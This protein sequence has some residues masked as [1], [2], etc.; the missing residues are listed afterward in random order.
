MKR[1][2]FRMTVTKLE[3]RRMGR[4]E[5]LLAC[6]QGIV[7]LSEREELLWERFRE[8]VAAAA[9]LLEVARQQPLVKGSTGQ[10]RAN[11]LFDAAARCD[12]VALDLWRE[13]AA[14]RLEAAR[15]LGAALAADDPLAA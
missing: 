12:R 8:N 10:Q 1:S 11:P 5:A 4:E 7:E 6:V 9:E 13:L 14:G 2:V 15:D 3:D